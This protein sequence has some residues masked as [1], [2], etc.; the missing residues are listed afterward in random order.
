[1]VFSEAKSR[2]RGGGGIPGLEKRETWG[3][4]LFWKGVEWFEI[5]IS[6]RPDRCVRGTHPCKERKDGAP[7]VVVISARNKARATRLISA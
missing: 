6:I 3:T 4:R 2:D 7:S 1:M 5:S